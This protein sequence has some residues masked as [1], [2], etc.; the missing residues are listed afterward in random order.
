M[1]APASDYSPAFG[2]ERGGPHEKIARVGGPHGDRVV[3]MP[4]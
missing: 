3:R 1:A 2:Y 4:F